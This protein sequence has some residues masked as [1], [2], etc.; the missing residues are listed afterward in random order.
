MKYIGS[1]E[2]NIQYIKRPGSYAIIIN[3]NDDKVGIVTVN[4]ANHGGKSSTYSP[5]VRNINKHELNS[6]MLVMNDKEDIK[7]I[8]FNMSEIR[9]YRSRETLGDAYRKPYAYKKLIEDNVQEPFIRKDSRR[10][11]T[12]QTLY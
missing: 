2:E 7:I 6:E 4:Y 11:F 12:I 1:K 9:E 3:K 10:N 8:Q 5:I